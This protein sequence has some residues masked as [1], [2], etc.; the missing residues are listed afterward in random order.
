MSS[1]KPRKH[2]NIRNEYAFEI[3]MIAATLL[4]LFVFTLA[5][6]ISEPSVFVKIGGV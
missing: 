4:I 3:G 1:L 6:A 5:I 2:T